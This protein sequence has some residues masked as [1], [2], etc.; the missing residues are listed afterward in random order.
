[1]TN[2]NT[3]IQKLIC[4]TE[5]FKKELEKRKR[6]IKENEENCHTLM[7]TYETSNRENHRLEN[8]IQ[9]LKIQEGITFF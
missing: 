9:Q 4:E 7:T 8:E 2:A 6:V 5:S 3:Q 1:M